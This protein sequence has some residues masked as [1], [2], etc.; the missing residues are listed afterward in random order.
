MVVPRKHLA[1]HRDA[2]RTESLL[3]RRRLGD[4][5]GE[6]VRSDDDEEGGRARLDA[7]ERR[8]LS[9]ALGVSAEDGVGDAVVPR[10]VVHDAHPLDVPHGRER[11]DAANLRRIEP[12]PGHLVLRR[13]DERREVAAGRV[14]HDV[15][16]RGIAAVIGRVLDRPAEARDDVV[17]DARDGHLGG[18]PV[19]LDHRDD[20][21]LRESGPDRAVE[22]R[23]AAVEVLV[24]LDPV[25]AVDEVDDGRAL[26]RLRR[27]HRGPGRVDVEA[28]LRVSAPRDVDHVPCLDDVSRWEGEPKPRRLARREGAGREACGDERRA[29]REERPFLHVGGTRRG[30][31]TVP[32]RDAPAH[33]GGIRPT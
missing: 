14:P 9:L 4:H 17:E 11:D 19:A 1:L 27:R 23:R 10:R 33:C 28:V 7:G 3:G 32:R 26:R 8:E 13:A 16:T 31:A 5:V 15:H 2:R 29:A 21:S 12:P 6:V 22:P 24:A 25:P 18:E 20:A 30:R